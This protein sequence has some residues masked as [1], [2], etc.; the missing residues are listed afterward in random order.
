MREVCGFLGLIGWYR[1]FIHSYA[2]IASPIR[3][4]LKKAKE[5]VW[6]PSVENAFQILKETLNNI[7]VL[8]LPKFSK[9]FM[10]TTDASRQAIGG[11]LSQEGKPIAF[12]SCKL[13]DHELNYP[14]HSLE[15]LAVVQTLK[16]WRHYLWG[17]IFL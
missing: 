7:P 10:V 4:T 13:R 17:V 14:I 15:L 3:V 12:K 2:W 1:I 6:T 16:I 8:A 9:P 11:D 5:L